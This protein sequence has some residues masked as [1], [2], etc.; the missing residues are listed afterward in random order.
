M[1]GG[2]SMRNPFSDCTTLRGDCLHT[3]RISL[4]S[5]RAVHRLERSHAGGGPAEDSAV[6]VGGGVI[7]AFR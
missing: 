2:R 6:L 7:G 1:F 5:D 4:S 3:A